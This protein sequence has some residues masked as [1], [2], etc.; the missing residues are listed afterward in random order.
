MYVVRS[1]VLVLSYTLYHTTVDELYEDRMAKIILAYRN[2]FRYLYCTVSSSLLLEHCT[3]AMSTSLG[4]VVVWNITTLR[5]KYV[6][7]LWIFDNVSFYQLSLWLFT[8]RGGLPT[9]LKCV[10]RQ[11]KIV[12]G[13]RWYSSLT[14]VPVFHQI[15][16]R[17]LSST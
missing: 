7:Y 17:S 11:L 8:M 10:Q 1:Q 3:S 15:S 2:A 5:L 4:E 12:H 13:P 6:Q 16:H 14:E 9:G